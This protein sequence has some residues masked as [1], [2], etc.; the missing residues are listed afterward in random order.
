[1]PRSAIDLPAVVLHA[2]LVEH[3][4]DRAERTRTGAAPGPGTGCWRCPAPARPRGSGRRSRCRRCGRPAGVLK[5]TSLAV[6]EDLAGVGGQAPVQRLDQGGL[7]G[8]VV[9]D[10]RQHLAGV[11]VEVDAVEADDPAEGLDQAAG[12]QDRSARVGESGCAEADGACST[13]RRW[14]MRHALT[15]RIHWSMDDGDDDQDADGQHPPL[16]VHPG[17]ATGRCGRRRRS[18]HRGWCRRSRRGHRTGWCR[19]S[20]RR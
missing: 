20:R 4:Q 1:M 17:Q 5:C 2:L 7:A 15:F 3:P 9:A 18:A 11:E 16:V 13:G 14:S 6:E 10:D 8:A 12:R 19:R